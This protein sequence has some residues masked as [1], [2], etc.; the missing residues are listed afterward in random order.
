MCC[1]SIPT[2]KRIAPPEEPFPYPDPVKVGG[3]H[4]FNVRLAEMAGLQRDTIKN[5][6]F[7]ARIARRN[8]MVAT[9][10]NAS[11]LQANNRQPVR[12]SSSTTRSS[13]P[14]K[15]GLYRKTSLPAGT[16]Q[17]K[18]SLVAECSVSSRQLAV[19]PKLP[20][21]CTVKLESGAS[22]QHS[23]AEKPTI[24]EN[25]ETNYP[26][27]CSTGSE[28]AAE[29][30]TDSLS[31]TDSNEESS[32]EDEG[33]DMQRGCVVQSEVTPKNH[34][35]DL[36]EAIFSG[37]NRQKQLSIEK[38]PTKNSLSES[39]GG[40]VGETDMDECTHNSSPCH[41]N[42]ISEDGGERND[43]EKNSTLKVPVK[44]APPTH[45][46][47][48]TS[49]SR[50]TPHIVHTSTETSVASPQV[51]SP[52]EASAQSSTSS[53][54]STPEHPPRKRRHHANRSKSSKTKKHSKKAVRQKKDVHSNK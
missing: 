52:N 53:S 5:E 32:E 36:V 3:D 21:N 9:S 45:H 41:A 29:H 28:I 46:V 48:L 10:S 8:A 27:L 34:H 39:H 15:T 19:P 37:E 26:S 38:I 30:T 23:L 42:T 47:N 35:R 24:M 25:D 7:R 50:P 18:P 33:I 20:S 22:L 6:E 13:M 51:V 43:K 16:V 17:D 40:T 44:T 2:P 54:S 12:P 49:K 4:A 31:V 1:R 14:S 11:N